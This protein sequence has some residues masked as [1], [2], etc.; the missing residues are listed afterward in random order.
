MIDIVLQVWEKQDLSLKTIEHLSM[1]GWA[2]SLSI[3]L[4]IGIGILI[5]KKKGIA[6]VVFNI[7]N[8]I[9]LIPTLALLILFL[10]IF[11][12]GASPTIAA[13]ILYSILPIARNTYTGLTNINKEYIEVAKGLGLTSKEILLKVRLPFSLPLIIGG[14]R[15]AIV[16]TMGVLTLG[17]LIA[18][19]G[20]GEAIQT[21]LQFINMDI[22]I[23]SSIWV[24]FLAVLFDGIAGLI[25]KKLKRRFDFGRSI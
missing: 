6:N 20:I 5:Y 21:G 11:G 4:G 23:V 22:I 14:I 1:F 3:I 25:E 16:F 13:C 2:L 17:G 8:V 15:I 12:L 24:G 19:G 10:P 9:E 7:L 18:A